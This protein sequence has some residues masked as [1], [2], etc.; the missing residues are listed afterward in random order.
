MKG[1]KNKWM[2]SGQKLETQP[3][4]LTK[5][6]IFHQ[7]IYSK[8][9]LYLS[10]LWILSLRKLHQK[11]SIFK[12][13]LYPVQFSQSCPTRWNPMNDSIPGL[14]VYHQL[15]ESTQTHVH[16]VSDAI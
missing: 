6:D 7:D 9:E 8:D 10:N 1:Q 12:A 13:S 2:E 14:P 11:K 3:N 15:P 16:W 5:H 4:S